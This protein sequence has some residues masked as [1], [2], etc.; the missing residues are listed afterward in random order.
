MENIDV[1][2][3]SNFMTN[4]IQTKNMFIIHMK[5]NVIYQIVV[6]ATLEPKIEI[7]I[8]KFLSLLNS[9][10]NLLVYS[11]GGVSFYPNNHVFVLT[12]LSERYNPY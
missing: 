12:I 3:M 5:N 2:I 1:G 9:K 6:Y 10:L 11:P 7:P 4:K 8:Y